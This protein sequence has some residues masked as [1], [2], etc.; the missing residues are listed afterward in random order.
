MTV[1]I[2]RE[3]D[4]DAAPTASLGQYRALDGS[5]G[6]A[7]ELDL[8]RPHAAL[9]VGKRGYG[10]S[11]TLGVLAEELARTAG[12]APV[13]IDPMGVFDSLADGRQDP[14]V[15]VDVVPAPT[16]APSMLDPRAW[17][18][19]LGLSPESGAGALVWQAARDATTLGDMQSAVES[20]DAPADDCLA[21]AN[22]L[23]LAEEW[24]VFDPDG[25]DRRLLGT[26]EATVIDVSGLDAAPMNA[27]VR[28]VAEGLY[29]ARVD[30]S[31]ERLP[32]LAIDEAHTFF[33]GV[34]QSALETI[35][36]RGRAPGVSLV[37]ATQRPGVIPE[38]AISQSDLL[39][40]HRLTDER[41][42]AALEDAQPTYL[43]GTLEE[44]LPTEPGEV[45]AIDDATE[46]VH[47]LHVRERETPHGGES[48]RSS[49]TTPAQ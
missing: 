34:A 37:L 3:T 48:P 14:P 5:E 25:L 7:V 44:R 20:S 4:G 24:C 42:L 28:G 12:V 33:E 19:L 40:A 16:V 38:V 47:A 31:I 21:A 23:A 45:L 1:V 11:Y 17:C 49:E 39:L 36:T 6:A 13:L 9:V 10:K 41:G 29:R 15:E 18:A 26:A 8:D 46:S 32:W 35:L 22:H 2:G 30:E 43:S 27:V